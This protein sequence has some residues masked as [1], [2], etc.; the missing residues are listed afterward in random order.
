M[1][2]DYIQN[3]IQSFF[4]TAVETLYCYRYLSKEET[5]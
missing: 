4:T 5:G 3:L 2:T 1:Y